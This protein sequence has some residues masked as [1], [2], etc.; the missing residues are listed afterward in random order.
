[1]VSFRFKTLQDIDEKEGTVK[2]VDSIVLMVVDF[3]NSLDARNYKYHK[4]SDIALVPPPSN[5]VNDPLNWPKWKKSAAFISI[6]F[7]T[8]LGSWIMGGIALGIPGIMTE[9]GV[10]LNKAVTGVVSWTVFT[11]GIGV[12]ILPP[13][14]VR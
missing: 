7:F 8:F 12:I 1:M 2:L 3:L 11:V 4:N 10:D 9:F 5:D 13:P 14:F 6:C